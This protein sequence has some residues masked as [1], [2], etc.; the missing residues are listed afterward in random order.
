MNT[1]QQVPATP[2]ALF[3]PVRSGL[4]QRKCACDGTPGPTGECQECREKALQR[5]TRSSALVPRNDSSVPPIVHEVLR[6]PGQPLDP[7]TRTFFE[8]RFGHDFSQVRVHTNDKAAESARSVNAL[9][10]TVGQN[11]AFG[12]GQYAPGTVNGARLLAHELTHVAQQADTGR[13]VT[14]PARALSK[15]SDAAEV[16]AEFA[17]NQVMQ[18]GRVA[19]KQQPNAAVHA[20]SD[21]ATRNIG[22]GAGILGGVGLGF[23]IAALAGA[24]DKDQF[25][26]SE[27][28]AYLGVLARTRQIEDHRDSDNKARDVVRRWRAGQSAY[29]ITS[30][31]R[32]ANG[33]LS[34]FDLKLLLIKEML[35]GTAGDEDEQAI[36]LILE[37]TGTEERTRIADRIGYDR[38]H[39]K[40][41]G[42][43]LDKLYAL[44]PQLASF[45]PRGDKAYTKYTF[46]E[47]IA[48]WEKEHG[49]VMTLEEKRSLAGGCIGVT[50]LNL[51]TLNNPDLSNCYDTFSQVWEAAH[52]MNE[53]LA[54]SFPTRKALIFSKRFWS[55]GRDF[56]PDETTGKVD[57]RER[58][59]ARPGFTNFD[60]GLYDEKTGKWWHANH[61]DEP[62]LAEPRCHGPME[63]YESNLQHYSRDLADFDR[64]IFCVAVTQNS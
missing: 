9:A 42:A 15:S 56:K 11:V 54:V 49:S 16:E 14:Q 48:K 40:F 17:A 35:S 2:T 47:Y 32:A 29:D 5:N 36:L 27:L 53:F 59:F 4:L 38:L 19:V 26:D 62:F 6:S 46:E 63:V 10:Y 33:A 22:I 57:M 61:C 18:G 34:G 23:G 60:Y 41:D 43:E 28:Q 21:E 51:F 31:Y 52:K 12:A 13:P 30:G 39:D 25:S 50:R 44:L 55:G 1:R 58:T 8:P 45:H 3:M 64:Q 37:A 24:F 20:L 7:A